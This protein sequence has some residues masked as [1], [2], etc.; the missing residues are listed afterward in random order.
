MH[1][2]DGGVQD[3]YLIDFLGCHHTHGPSY[4][5]ALDDVSQLL[6]ALVSQLL[7]VVQRLILIVFWEDDG[8]SIH[9]AS[10][11]ASASLVAACLHL[12]CIVMACQHLLYLF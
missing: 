9:A 10:Q 5:V 6:S 4:G 8:S 7:R 12:A 11:T 2:Q 1:G 3:V